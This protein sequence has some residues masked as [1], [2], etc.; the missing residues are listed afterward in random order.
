MAIENFRGNLADTLKGVRGAELGGTERDLAKATLEKAKTTEPYQASKKEH[1]E[2][3]KDIRFKKLVAKNV[4]LKQEIVELERR[5][6]VLEEIQGLLID[7]S[8]HSKSQQR[9]EA[10][11]EE[12][13]HLL[14]E[15]IEKEIQLTL[16]EI[17]KYPVDEPSIGT[18]YM[19]AKGVMI[20]EKGQNFPHFDLRAPE[21]EPPEGIKYSLERSRN[22]FVELKRVLVELIAGNAKLFSDKDGSI[23]AFKKLKHI[24]TP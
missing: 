19:A 6:S 16:E 10:N 24:T 5:T 17:D 7:G 4:E 3:E 18:E 21:K 9:N 8:Y 14:L 15:A 2:N 13:E 20:H 11:L 23:R 22:R 1:R 12:I